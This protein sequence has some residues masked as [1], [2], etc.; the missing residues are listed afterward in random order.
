[1]EPSDRNGPQRPSGFFSYHGWLAPGVRLFRGLSF[2]A[3]S[4][5]LLGTLLVPICGLLFMLYR[6]NAQTMEVAALERQGLVY[7]NAVNALRQDMAALREASMFKAP[8]MA[9]RRSH[10]M[11]SWG[12][13]QQQQVQLGPVFDGQTDAAFTALDKSLQ[14]ALQD[15]APSPDAQFAS[16]AQAAQACMALL[17]SIGDGSQLALDPQIDTYHMTNL[18]VGIGPQYDEYLASLQQL[19]ALSLGQDKGH[20]LSQQRRQVIE[21]Y[22]H[23]LDYLDPLYENSYHKGIEAFPD[24]AQA[25][26]MA[27]VDKTRE[28]F[29]AAMNQQTLGASVSG[30]A[31]ALVAAATAARDKQAQLNQRVA[32][33]LDARLQE[34]LAD[35]KTT[36]YLEFAIPLVFFSVTLYLMLAFYRVMR[37]GLELVSRHLNE[38]SQGDLRYRPIEP[39]GRDEPAA[40]IIDLHK[41]YDSMRELI[42]RV[43]HSARELAITSA[44]VS[45]AS[46][47]LSGR[48]EAAASNLGHQATAIG[49][50]G[51][52]TKQS[53]QRTMEAAVMAQ[54][55]A[56]V[57]EEGGQIIDNVIDTM[58]RLQESSKRI[59]EIIG[60]IDGIA[61][62][63]NIL[64][65][66]AAVEAARAGEQGRGFAVVATEVRALAGRSAAA[67]REIKELIT[68]SVDQITAGGHVVERAGYNM[69]ELV[70]NAKQINHFLSDISNATSMQ[71][72]R[73]DEIVSAIIELDV[74]TQQN[75]TLVEETSASAESLSNQADGLTQEIARFRVS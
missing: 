22:M 57:A 35:A 17:G 36:M 16:W 31:S 5:W 21:R 46:Q 4:A 75:A 71:A 65:L 44:E 69:A 52:Q 24:V 62:Q 39:R 60:T 42:R 1:M 2:P 63:T 47:D 55:N 10:V 74:H 9:E 27:G 20:A 61:F 68:A 26:D 33:R 50:I 64:A 48:T 56:G 14:A 8:D 19:G 70:A 67:A 23:L 18:V 40:L 12:Q 37:G 15:N 13:V 66:N 30:E 58:R 6:A 38:L 73:V 25:L 11:S 7:V 45:R 3:K 51:E 43:R 72:G 28:T 54:G 34:R 53:A 29:L 32:A 59:S 49:D 41:V